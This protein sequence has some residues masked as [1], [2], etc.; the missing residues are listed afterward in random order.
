MRAAVLYAGNAV[1]ANAIKGD[2]LDKR[3]IAPVIITVIL[4]L[5]FVAF[6]ALLVAIGEEMPLIVTIM[7]LSV[8][9]ICIVASVYVLI[10][11]IKEIRS[12]VEDD[13]D[14]Y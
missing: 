4:L 12:G 11:R 5:Y 13:L 2:H 7:G 8:P 1:T 6:G 3:M 9:A 14:K 10:E